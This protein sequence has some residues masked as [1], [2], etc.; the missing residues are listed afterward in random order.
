MRS[1]ESSRSLRQLL[2][3]EEESAAAAAAAPPPCCLVT[4]AEA[5]VNRRIPY[6]EMLM[7]F[8]NALA[9]LIGAY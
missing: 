1:R 4:A 7:L 2:E 6:L 3:E 9:V 8:Y 5:E